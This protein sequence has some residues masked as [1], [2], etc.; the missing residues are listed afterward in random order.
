MKIKSL[1]I[2]VLAFL[3]G[4]VAMSAQTAKEVQ[5]TVAKMESGSALC[6]KGAE[7]F[8]TFIAK[9]S[10][11]EEFMNSRIKLSDAQRTEFADL[12]VPSN[13]TAKEPFEKDGDMYYQSWGELQYQ[14]TY[15][16]CGW[17][18]SYVTHTF[19]FERLDGKW[20]LHKVIADE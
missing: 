16:D 5:A 13:F 19:M 3:M 18:D 9:F 15:L 12:L 11:D 4:G 8:K 17:V 7:P 6:N 14:K 10:A 1:F 20:Y 2:A